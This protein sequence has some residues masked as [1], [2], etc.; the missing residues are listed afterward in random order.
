MRKTL[1]GV[2][3]RGSRWDVFVFG[4]RRYRGRREFGGIQDAAKETLEGLMFALAG[5]AAVVWTHPNRN[6][7]NRQQSREKTCKSVRLDCRLFEMKE[8]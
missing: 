3:S 4:G 1:T 8:R 2:R 6:R 5:G 7:R